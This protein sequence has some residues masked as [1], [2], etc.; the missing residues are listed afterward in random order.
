MTILTQKCVLVNIK[1]AI[2]KGKT[3]KMAKF[4][5]VLE[6]NKGIS[7]FN[8]I[9]FP[10]RIIISEYTFEQNINRSA[11]TIACSTSDMRNAPSPM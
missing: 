6:K 2:L 3:F 8:L 11:A 1:I 10:R 7:S 4:Y 9:L 5:F